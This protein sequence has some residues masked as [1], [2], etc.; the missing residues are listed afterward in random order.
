MSQASTVRPIVIGQPDTP[1][2][3]RTAMGDAWYQLSRNRLAVFGLGFIILL[4]VVALSAD[5]IRGTGLIEGINDQHRGSS[6]VPPL[7]CAIF[8]PNQKPYPP[9][10]PQFCFVFGSDSLGRD[11]VSRTIYGTRVSLAVAVVGATMSLGIG[12]I[13]GVILTIIAPKIFKEDISKSGLLKKII[14]GGVT[15]VG[16]IL[17][18]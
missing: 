16:L 5:I 15:L 18:Y 1:F 3:R 13:Y 4:I 11:V 6:L 17:I 10:A 2:R 8:Q 9:G 14:L 12:V 7:S